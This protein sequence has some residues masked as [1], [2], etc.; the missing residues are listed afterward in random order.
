M[1][2]L[3]LNTWNKQG[4]WQK[5]WERIF[6]EISELQPD[7]ILF[8][9]VFDAEWAS[10]IARRT[11]YPSSAFH[12]PASGLALFSKFPLLDSGCRILAA[13]SPREDYRRYLL[14]AKL[15]SPEGVFYAF[16]THLSWM[17]EDWDVRKAQTAQIASFMDEIAGSQEAVIGGDFNTVAWSQEIR[18][19]VQEQS[20]VDLYREVEPEAPGLTWSYDNGYTRTGRHALPDRRIDYLFTRHAGRV[21]G[22][23]AS[24]RC[25]MTEPDAEGIWASDHYGV[26]AELK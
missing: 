4:P 19:L 2:I 16:D 13:Q 15:Q 1:K 12:E 22:K 26:F 7:L 6:S 14:Y 24:V 8:Q 17:L 18:R 3:T 10:E 25:V 21:L 23:P 5:R 9:E 20:Y 11:G